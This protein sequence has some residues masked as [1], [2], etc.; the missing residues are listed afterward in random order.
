MGMLDFLKISVKKEPVKKG[1]PKPP[2]NQVQIDS[3]SFPLGA[4]TVS[5][6][7]ATGFDGS[8]VKGQNAKL[9]VS[10]DDQFAKFNFSATVT[11]LDAAGGKLTA[12]FG[13]LPTETEALIR[14][15]AQLRKQKPG[16]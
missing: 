4:I 16:K 13:M 2:N 10:V 5:G 15:Y 6:L 9:S 8:L 7:V 3:K 1:P 12:Q 14:K 11:V